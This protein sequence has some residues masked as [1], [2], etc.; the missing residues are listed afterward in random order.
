[1]NVKTRVTS[2][3]Q[4]RTCRSNISFACSSYESGTPTGRARVG[5]GDASALVSAF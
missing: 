3:W 2:A 5:I 4:A 1:M